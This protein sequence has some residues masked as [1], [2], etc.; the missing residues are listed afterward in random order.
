VEGRAEN[1]AGL[2]NAV[3]RVLLETGDT[4]G[5]SDWYDRGWSTIEKSSLAPEQRTIWQV[6]HRHAQA[7]I[8]AQRREPRRAATLADETRALMDSDPANAEHYKAIYPYLIG[9]LR[10]QERK[11]P[12][13]IEQLALAETDQPFIQYLMAEAYARSRDRA[14]ARIWYEKALRSGAGLDSE[15]AIVRPLAAAWLAKNPAGS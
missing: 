11:Y 2:C 4:S 9:Y 5:A 7:R 10:L 13:A 6:R 14:N 1:S 8:A 12:E 3:G 15:S